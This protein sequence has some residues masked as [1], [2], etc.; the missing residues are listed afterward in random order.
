MTHCDPWVEKGQE[1]TSAATL[2]TRAP[3]NVPDELPYLCF[4]YDFEKAVFDALLSYNVGVIYHLHRFATT[5]NMG[6]FVDFHD[7][8]SAI[9]I[10]VVA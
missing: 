4:S 8:L 7:F 3:F 5:I 1:G 6:T 10:T 9:E 2:S